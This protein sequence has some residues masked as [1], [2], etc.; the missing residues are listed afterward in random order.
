MLS[1]TRQDAEYSRHS[2]ARTRSRGVPQRCRPAARS[3]RPAGVSCHAAL[4]PRNRRWQERRVGTRHARARLNAG[5]AA[6]LGCRPSPGLSPGGLRGHGWR[7][8][9]I[10][11]V[12]SMLAVQ[13]PRPL[14]DRCGGDAIWLLIGNT[15]SVNAPPRDA[16]GIA[17]RGAT[18][19]R[20]ARSGVRSDGRWW[21]SGPPGSSGPPRWRAVPRPPAR[22]PGGATLG[23]RVGPVSGRSRHAGPPAFLVGVPDGRHARA[24]R[25]PLFT[26]GDGDA[27]CAERF[28]AA[29]S[30]RACGSSKLCLIAAQLGDP[31]SSAA[32]R[33][34]AGGR[35]RGG[36]AASARR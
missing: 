30:Y 33:A 16:R 26:K 10:C 2:E 20:R 29:C 18:S 8:P 14:H 19:S 13:R 34:R 5:A 21:P 36:G 6:C 15:R 25:T 32:A 27:R 4:G 7:S 28:G 1:R 23:W 31:G 11:V 3:E 17:S 24:E 12:Q 22:P 9:R 35:V